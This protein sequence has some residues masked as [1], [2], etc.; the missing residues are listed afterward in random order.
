MCQ[1]DT[2]LF[3]TLKQQG[4]NPQSPGFLYLHPI[5]GL[6]DAWKTFP[7]SGVKIKMAPILP[8]L[9]ITSP[10]HVNIFITSD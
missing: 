1:S 6:E 4:Q 9:L 8:L 5:G 3:I 7:Q 10:K 2:S